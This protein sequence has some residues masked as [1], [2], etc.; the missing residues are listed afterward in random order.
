MEKRKFPI[1]KRQL[2]LGGLILLF[3]VLIADL[4]SRLMEMDRLNQ[5]R[6]QMATR[7]YW[8]TST[9]AV[10]KTQ[11]AY[12]QSDAAVE[13]WAREEGH[14]MKEGDVVIVPMVPK[15]AT[16]QPEILPTATPQVVEEID[17]W[18]AIFFGD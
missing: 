8:V 13:E 18:R 9:E 7:Y 11:I 4:N 5:E 15:D 17:A 10:L 3:I 12:A 2:L 1:E 14:M 6:D 16:E